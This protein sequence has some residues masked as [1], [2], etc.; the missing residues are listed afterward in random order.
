MRSLRQAQLGK[1]IDRARYEITTLQR[2][3]DQG[4]VGT[5]NAMGVNFGLNA[6]LFYV[7]GSFGVSA[8]CLTD[9]FDPDGIIGVYAQDTT[10][11]ACRQANGKVEAQGP[12]RICSQR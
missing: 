10:M 12:D 1:I 8:A 3:I 7:T 2:L 9:C 5:A 6:G 4:Y 11:S